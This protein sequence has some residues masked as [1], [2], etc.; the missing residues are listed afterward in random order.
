[1]P[2]FGP[3][4]AAAKLESSKVFAY[5]FMQRHNI[6]TFFASSFVDFHSAKKYLRAKP[7]DEI[8]VKADGL[9]KGKGVE[10]PKS[11]RK[12]ERALYKNLVEKQ[13]GTASE[14]VLVQ[15]RG[16]GP[17]LSVFA[18]CDGENAVILPF[19]R[20]YKR[21]KDGNKGPNTGG[22][23]NYGSVNVDPELTKII[24]QDIIRPT[25]EGMATEQQPYKGILYVGLMLTKEGPK[26]IEYNA[27]F[28]DPECQ[29][30][31]LLIDEDI[32][33]HLWQAA[34][35]VLNTEPIK[36]RSG[37]AVTIALAAKGYPGTPRQQ[38]EIYGL[39]MI[40]KLA[41]YDIHVFHGAT[42]HKGDRII[43]DGGRVLHIA[44]HAETLK[45]VRKKAYSV[46]GEHAIHF[47]GMQYRTD[48]GNSA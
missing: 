12:A 1:L 46:I 15:D 9:A 18:I 38:D 24:E 47:A 5:N 36:I 8:V 34:K 14:T 13:F 31:M 43:T 20:D 35:G 37:A 25:V 16:E 22:M 45:K 27:R 19:C 3:T 42:K 21:L 33:P 30:L 17:E 23:G 6:P 11:A 41:K 32:Y 29:A 40:T 28:G 2:I 7:W 10:V 48:I 26:V 44:A 39:E 4:K